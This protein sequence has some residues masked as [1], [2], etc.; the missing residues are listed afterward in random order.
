MS[1]HKSL[2]AKGGMGRSRNVLTRVER[3]NVLREEGRW[4]DGD[5]VYGLPKVRTRQV[6]VGGKKKKKAAPEE[7]EKAAKAKK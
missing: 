4:G 3:L 6:K 2:K 7:D 1:L 5:A